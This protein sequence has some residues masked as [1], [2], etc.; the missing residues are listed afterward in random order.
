MPGAVNNSTEEGSKRQPTEDPQR[1]AVLMAFEK[2]ALIFAM[3]LDYREIKHQRGQWSATAT[4]DIPL[5]ES[6]PT[7][8]RGRMEAGW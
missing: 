3:P 4:R 8:P 5:T 2:L 6:D 7:H 1:R